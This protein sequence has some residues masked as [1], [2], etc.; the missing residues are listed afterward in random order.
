MVEYLMVNITGHILANNNYVP[1]ARVISV[2][3]MKE[4]MHMQDFR[5]TKSQPSIHVS[6]LGILEKALEYV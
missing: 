3:S 6:A 5:V 4:F 2:D 1:P